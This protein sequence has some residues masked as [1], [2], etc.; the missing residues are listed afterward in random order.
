VSRF[1]QNKWSSPE[2]DPEGFRLSLIE[3]LEELRTRIMRALYIICG[4]WIFSWIYEVQIREFLTNRAI[5]AM[6]A[7]VPKDSSIQEVVHNAPEF[8]MIKMKVSFFLALLFAFP[9]L[10][11]QVWAFVAPG[12]KPNEQR[13]FKRL[14]PLSLILFIIGGLFCWFI[15]PSAFTWFVSY[16]PDFHKTIL[17]QE[18]GS[19]AMFSL[20]SILAF[21]IGFQLPLV[22]Y[23]LGALNLLSAATLIKYWR[24]AAVAIFFLAGAIT[25]S[26]DPMTM[27]MMAVPLTVLFMISAWAVKITQ[28]NKKQKD[29]LW[30][31]DS[32]PEKISEYEPN[33]AIEPASS[34]STIPATEVVET[35]YAAP[36]AYNQHIEYSPPIDYTPPVDY[37][38]PID[39]EKLGDDH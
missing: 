14:A 4:A 30:K 8:F 35:S 9:F 2:H 5:N 1:S 37:N 34:V 16:M 24:H 19:L 21:G 25:P 11:L 38:E 31:E 7:N 26:N 10:V 33:S 23:I 13:P 27:L 22:V 17:N 36:E 6:I 28:G 12:L 15:L 29:L 3:H 39:P 20:K 18:A 32:E